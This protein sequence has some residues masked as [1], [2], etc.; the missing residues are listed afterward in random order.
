MQQ[1]EKPPW[2][3]TDFGPPYFKDLM[4]PVLKK[5][6]GKWAYHEVIRPGVIKRVAESGDVVY[7]VRFGTPR[8]VSIY[9]IRELCDIADKYCDGYLRWTSRHNVEF[10][11]TDESK[12]DDLIKEVEEKVGFPCGGT[13]DTPRG[14]Y[15]LTNIIHTQGWIHCHTP[16]I[17][18]SGIV[19]AI[20][21]ELYEYFVDMKLPGLCRISLAC[22]ANMCGAVHASDISI[23][24]IHRTPPLVDDDAVR[25]MCELP[26]TA[27][28]CP[29]AA[30]KV[31]AKEKTLEVDGEKCMY[32]GNCYTMCPGMP[33]FDPE[34]DGAAILCAGKVSDARHPP[35]LSK[36]V[37]PWVPNE[38]PRWPTLV[39]KVKKIFMA[40]ANNAKKH[41]RMVEFIERIGWERFFDL[42]GLE[43]SWHLIDDFRVPPF[44]YAS[45][46]IG[47]QFRW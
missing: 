32:C 19:K 39:E 10:I 38:P 42:A 40:W 8:L 14:K 3:K 44:M 47:T 27:A 36:V 23:V 17:D 6:Y 12:I 2:W 1:Q 20:M 24:G 15:G 25:R 37:V 31:K 16:A 28:A 45:Y 22:C 7:V 29:T 35:E 4:H 43:F 26:S 30:I 46:R 13:W 41:E 9:T 33:L 5:N 34:N 18:A 21:D 11:L